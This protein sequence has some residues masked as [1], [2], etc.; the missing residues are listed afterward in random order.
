MLT[1]GQELCRL[2]EA[3]MVRQDVLVG[4]SSTIHRAAVMEP[5]L[6]HYTRELIAYAGLQNGSQGFFAP[7]RPLVN[8]EGQRWEHTCLRCSPGRF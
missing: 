1:C 6:A 3:E 4:N 5:Y 7:K 2:I 8:L